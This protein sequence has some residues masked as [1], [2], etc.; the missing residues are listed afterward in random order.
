[1]LH[2]TVGW[3]LAHRRPPRQ[4]SHT[5]MG[6]FLWLAAQVFKGPDQFLRFVCSPALS[7]ECCQTD[8]SSLRPEPQSQL[9][10]RPVGAS[11]HS[12][13]ALQNPSFEGHSQALRRVGGS[14]SGLWFGRSL[15]A[16]GKLAET[17]Y[18][19]QVY[20]E[21]IWMSDVSPPWH[22]HFLFRAGTR[23]SKQPPPLPSLAD[24]WL[25]RAAIVTLLLFS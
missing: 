17:P 21:D 9:L 13:N 7:T 2:A 4:A 1:V 23:D 25:P 16:W 8:I 3:S 20:N 6:G 11:A 14:C 10:L 12:S 15:T 19:V 22:I 24:L 18:S 5:L